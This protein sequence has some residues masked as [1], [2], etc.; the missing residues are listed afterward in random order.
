[1]ANITP[2]P[3]GSA[4]VATKPITRPITLIRKRDQTD[5]G[6]SP[7]PTKRGRVTFD[8]NVK[9]QDLHDWERAPEVILERV[10]RAIRKHALGDNAAYN[11]LKAVFDAKGHEAT[12]YSPATMRSYISALLSNVSS[13]NKTCADL[14]H[15]LLN[16]EWLGREDDYVKIFVRIVVNIA[17]AQGNFLADVLRMLVENLHVGKP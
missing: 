11:E 2:R 10:R 16:S 9:V 6:S 5:D 13:L 15:S 12:D 8:D 7:V 4:P 14:V 3:A 17:S 1:M